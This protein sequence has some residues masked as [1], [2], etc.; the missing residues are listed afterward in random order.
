M[1]NQLNF[2]TNV[3]KCNNIPLYGG[4]NIFYDNFNTE[5][6]IVIKASIY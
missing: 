5:Y 4:Y 6:P 2:D 3:S 1:G